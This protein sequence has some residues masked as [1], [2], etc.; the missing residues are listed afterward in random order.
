MFGEM[1]RAIS[2]LS[3]E[4]FL[5][6]APEKVVNGLK[7]RRAELEVLIAKSKSALADLGNTQASN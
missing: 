5:S 1:E 7:Q 3:N 6:K 2:Q 4:T